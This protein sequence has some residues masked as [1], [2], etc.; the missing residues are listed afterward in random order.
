MPCISSYSICRINVEFF[1][2]VSSPAPFSFRRTSFLEPHFLCYNNILYGLIQPYGNIK[3]FGTYILM[4]LFMLCRPAYLKVRGSMLYR[5]NSF[6]DAANGG[7][8]V[9]I[10]SGDR[11]YLWHRW[12]YSGGCAGKIRKTFRINTIFILFRMPSC[13]KSVTYTFLYTLIQT[14]RHTGAAVCTGLM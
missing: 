12:R 2:S 3:F 13:K 4:V 6:V 9:R 5:Y 8:I 1:S 7:E 14:A 11:K 10:S